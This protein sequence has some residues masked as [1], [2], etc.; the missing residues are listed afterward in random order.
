VA[1]ATGT[2]A[3]KLEKLGKSARAAV[4]GGLEEGRKVLA[5]VLK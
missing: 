3:G 2:V 1:S 5:K 4:D